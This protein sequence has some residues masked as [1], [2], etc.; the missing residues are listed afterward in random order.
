M[1]GGG[2]GEGGGYI[3]CVLVAPLGVT[4]NWGMALSEQVE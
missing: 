3:P 4:T 1:R 2:G